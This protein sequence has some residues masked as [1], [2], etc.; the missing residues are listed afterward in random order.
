MDF[1]YPLRTGVTPEANALAIAAMMGVDLG[2]E[3]DGVGAAR[4]QAVR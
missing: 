4:G 2:R 1:D 3:S